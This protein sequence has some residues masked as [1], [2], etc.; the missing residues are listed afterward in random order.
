MTGHAYWPRLA[1]MD[2]GYDGERR[3]RAAG[4]LSDGSVHTHV[5]RK[6]SG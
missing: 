5:M 4:Q 3:R 2:D 1:D 6:W